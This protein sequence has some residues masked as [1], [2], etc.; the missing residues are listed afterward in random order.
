M[1]YHIKIE[2]APAIKIENG[3]L[4][5]NGAVEWKML[6]FAGSEVFFKTVAEAKKYSKLCRHLLGKN[7]VFAYTRAYLKTNKDAS[8]G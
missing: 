5:P 6:C 2:I 7:E 1:K 4:V 3:S 8:N